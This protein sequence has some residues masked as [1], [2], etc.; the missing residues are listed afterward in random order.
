MEK[1]DRQRCIPILYISRI[2]DVEQIISD[3]ISVYC[4]LYNVDEKGPWLEKNVSSLSIICPNPDRIQRLMTVIQ[5]VG[6]NINPNTSVYVMEAYVPDKLIENNKIPYIAVDWIEAITILTR[7]KCDVGIS[8]EYDNVFSR[9]YSIFNKKG[10]IEDGSNSINELSEICNTLPDKEYVDMYKFSN[11]DLLL[12]LLRHVNK[13]YAGLAVEN[14]LARLVRKDA[15]QKPFTVINGFNY[16]LSELNSY[17]YFINFNLG[18]KQEKRQEYEVDFKKL[19]RKV[20]NAVKQIDKREKEEARAKEKER[21]RAEKEEIARKKREY[22]RYY[23]KVDER[24]HQ[25][26]NSFDWWARWVAN[27][28]TFGLVRPPKTLRSDSYRQDFIDKNPGVFGNKSYFCIY[29]G[30]RIFADA[31]DRDRK[32]YVDH[33]K[34]VNQGGRN[35]TWN[36]GP[37]CFDCNSEKSDKGGNWIIRGYAGKLGFTALQTAYNMGK[38]L[39]WGFLDPSPVKKVASIGFWGFLG[40][41]FFL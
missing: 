10:I 9:G 16:D 32:M 17:R 35:S 5:M 41:L 11:E 14:T 40:Y 18:R 26:Q 37:S 25:D 6:Q 15:S 39:V 31:K 36:L 29:C 3:D 28:V 19:D 21:I 2:I 8:I 30:K 20:S 27:K 34:P 12:T 22:G 1:I 33:I 24:V 13:R 23:D 7:R 38:T 4:E